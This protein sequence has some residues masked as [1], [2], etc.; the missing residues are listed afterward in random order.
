MAAVKILISGMAN[1]GKTTLLK[2][3]ED[4]FIVARDGKKYPFP[5]AHTN[6]PD[7]KYKP[8][9]GENQGLTVSAQ[10]INLINTKLGAYKDK[11]GKL[12]KTVVFDSISK[13]FLDIES[14]VMEK[15]TS[16]PY[17]VI[18]TEIASIVNYI[19]ETLIPND[20]N[21]IIVS[22]AIYDEDAS[23]YKLVN[24]GGQYGKKGG[25]ISEVDNAIFV[26]AKNN[27]R[28]VHHKSLKF[29]SRTLHEELPDNLPV[30]E[31]NLQD[32]INLLA[33]SRNDTKEFE[34]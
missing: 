28:V 6:I 11:Y 23:M 19:E 8:T 33:T 24:A 21:V 9:E 25:F 22:H 10:Y 34:L 31:Y 27:K 4:V 16:F 13:I 14:A 26:E 5:Q 18:N 30:A 17:G 12:P 20:I 3:L 1:T 15:V 29:I 32:H 2:T 7:L